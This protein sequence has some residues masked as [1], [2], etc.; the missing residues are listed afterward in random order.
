MTNTTTAQLGISELAARVEQGHRG[1]CAKR[2]TGAAECTC[3]HADA[4][5]ALESHGGAGVA[6]YSLFDLVNA[7]DSVYVEAMEAV[8]VGYGHFI[9]TASDKDQLRLS[10]C[11]DTD[12]HFEDQQVALLATGEVLAVDCPADPEDEGT[13]YR[14]LLTVDRPLTA[15]D[16]LPKA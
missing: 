9:T 8:E 14:L 4:E 10:C 3:G 1:D 6:T 12:F 5:E 11:D 13:T 7:A 2:F 16:L 15:S